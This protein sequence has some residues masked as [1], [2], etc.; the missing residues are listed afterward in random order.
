MATVNYDPKVVK[1]YVSK[2][3]N[4]RDLGKASEAGGDFNAAANCYRQSF[5]LRNRVLG[6]QHPEVMKDAHKLASMLQKDKKYTQ[7]ENYLN[8]CLKAKARSHGAG[9][10]EFAETRDAL[11]NLYLEQKLYDKAINNFKQSVALNERFKGADSKSTYKAKK[12]LAK[13][14]LK[15]GDREKFE[16]IMEAAHVA[17]APTREAATAATTNTTTIAAQAEK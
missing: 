11:G 4:Y 15:S 1:E 3:N 8:W 17:Y 10:Y 6:H 13:A 12:K 14:Y 2:A 16:E 5:S 7:A 9:S